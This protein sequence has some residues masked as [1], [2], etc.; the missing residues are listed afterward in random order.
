VLVDEDPV[1][2]RDPGLRGERGAWLHPDANDD[3]PAPAVGR[4]L[5]RML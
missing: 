1:I 4:A 5:L 3:D 2:D